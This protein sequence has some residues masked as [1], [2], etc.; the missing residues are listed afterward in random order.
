MKYKCINLDQHDL[1]LTKGKYYEAEVV[2]EPKEFAGGKFLLIKRA[3][4]GFPAY[5][6]ISKFI[7]E[8]KE[9]RD[10]LGV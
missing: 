9:S 10:E 2:V 5:A 4:D 6:H 7:P 3:D 1:W 8:F